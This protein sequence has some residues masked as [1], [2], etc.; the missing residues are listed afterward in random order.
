MLIVPFGAHR[1]VALS[2][3]ISALICLGSVAGAHAQKL[4]TPSYLKNARAI[5]FMANEVVKYCPKIEEDRPV[6]MRFLAG[7]KKKLAGDG[8]TDVKSQLGPVPFSEI[9]AKTTRMQAEN[10][11]PFGFSEKKYCAYGRKEIKRRNPVGRL[12]KTSGS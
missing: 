12:L 4:E 1:T 9:I 2:W 10:G 3:A 7:L 8:I 11:G 5:L 6:V